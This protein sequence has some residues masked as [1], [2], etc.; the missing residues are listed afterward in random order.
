[1]TDLGVWLVFYG[2]LAVLGSA[3]TLMVAYARDEIRR[4]ERRRLK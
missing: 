4:Q 3:G 1:M 2:L